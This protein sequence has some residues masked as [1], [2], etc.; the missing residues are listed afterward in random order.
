MFAPADG[1]ILDK[2]V[3]PL[4]HAKVSFMLGNL[5]GTISMCGT[6]AEMLAI[7]QFEMA[8]FVVGGRKATDEDQKALF[9][10]T[11][12]R[13]GQERRVAILRTLGLID[14]A[15]RICFDHIREVR[16]K[17]LHFWSKDHG[18][19]ENDATAVYGDAITL[20]VGLIG[21]DIQDG[22]LKL[23]EPFVKY[24]KSRGL[25]MSPGEAESEG[26][27]RGLTS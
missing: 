7:L 5:L 11:F 19:I 18:S 27:K 9:G 23:N 2:L 25:V 17:Y 3:W 21:Q 4:K 8:E 26:S 20:V 16:R 22:R 13:L 12:E 6:A 1:R 10:S 15:T 24:L 14:D